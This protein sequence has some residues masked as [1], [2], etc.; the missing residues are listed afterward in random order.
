MF[1]T[2]CF[3][4]QSNSFATTVLVAVVITCSCVDRT[5]NTELFTMLAI[6]LT[7]TYCVL[8]IPYGPNGDCFVTLKLR[9]ALLTKHPLKKRNFIIDFLFS[10]ILSYNSLIEPST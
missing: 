3:P 7:K 8:E 9:F 1:K 2:F 10:L 6:F 4:V 5:K